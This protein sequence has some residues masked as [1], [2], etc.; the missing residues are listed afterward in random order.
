[1][2]PAGR[3]HQARFSPVVA[4]WCLESTCLLPW[5]LSSTWKNDEVELWA[6]LGGFL[7]SEN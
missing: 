6:M 2:G 7:D 3:G 5:G 1:M 4:A